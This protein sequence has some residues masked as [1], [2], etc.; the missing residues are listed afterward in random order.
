MA[1]ENIF[2]KNA[3]KEEAAPPGAVELHDICP[4]LT[5]PTFGGFRPSTVE[6]QMKGGPPAMPVLTA[7]MVMCIG[8]SCSF[9]HAKRE[10]CVLVLAANA[11]TRIGD[12]KVPVPEGESE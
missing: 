3:K 1:E 4:F 5:S 6:Q 11:L 2:K 9:W 8:E 7:G 10:A 12:K